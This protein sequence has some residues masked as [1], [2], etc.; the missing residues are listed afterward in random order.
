MD[1]RIRG[2]SN[3]KEEHASKDKKQPAAEA[4]RQRLT[5]L[6]TAA[7]TDTCLSRKIQILRILVMLSF[8][9]DFHEKK[10]KASVRRVIIPEI[11]ANAAAKISERHE[12]DGATQDLPR[13][14]MAK[15][16]ACAV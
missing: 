15:H 14:K 16:T 2:R 11:V 9:H 4:L 3:A 10:F 12:T 8:L 1:S 5:T 7:A 13:R 6:I